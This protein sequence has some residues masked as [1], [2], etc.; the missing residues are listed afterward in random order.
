MILGFVVKNRFAPLMSSINTSKDNVDTVPGI[1]ETYKGNGNPID[2]GFDFQC[3]A[4]KSWYEVP[5]IISQNSFENPTMS[6]TGVSMD[7]PK[8]GTELCEKKD[9]IFVIAKS[10]SFSALCYFCRMAK[11][12][13]LS[14]KQEYITR[15]N[16]SDIT[17]NPKAGTLSSESINPFHLDIGVENKPPTTSDEWTP[18]V[19]Q[20]MAFFPHYP[21]FTWKDGIAEDIISYPDDQRIFSNLDYNV[22]FGDVLPF[23]RKYYSLKVFCIIKVAN[24]YALLGNTLVS[25]PTPSPGVLVEPFTLGYNGG[26]NKTIKIN[27]KFGDIIFFYTDT[28]T[29]PEPSPTNE[30]FIKIIQSDHKIEV[31]FE[32]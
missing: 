4:Y 1:L 25:Y 31:E 9:S 13:T 7:Y 5:E 32:D 10:S 12:V 3:I 18:Y 16:G 26:T 17:T 21:V 27:T 6:Q 19:F 24:E 23:I 8:N 11:K 15:I 14:F 28:K 2:L 30:R 20:K 22:D 29:N